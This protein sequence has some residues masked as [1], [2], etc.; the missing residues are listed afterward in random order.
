V[1]S[2]RKR[3]P[4]EKAALYEA[5]RKS[6]KLKRG[7]KSTAVVDSDEEDEWEDMDNV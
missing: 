4:T 2:K 5:S 1:L 3:K 7:A 6:R